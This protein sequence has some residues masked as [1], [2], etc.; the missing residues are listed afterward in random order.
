MGYGDAKPSSGDS[1][2]RPRKRQDR[3]G[4]VYVVRNK[5]GEPP[6]K[7]S[8]RERYWQRERRGVVCRPLSAA[9]RGVREPVDNAAGVPHVA[10]TRK[11]PVTPLFRAG[12]RC[13]HKEPKRQKGCPH[14][15]KSQ[16][17]DRQALFILRN[18]KPKEERKAAYTRRE[19]GSPTRATNR[20]LSLKDAP[21]QQIKSSSEIQPP[22][23]T[24]K[25]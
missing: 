21:L 10:D 6:T 7:F 9:A 17:H 23:A 19:S 5:K 25:S 3:G 16:I 14:P 4:F 13:I 22:E 15:S 1:V 11:M 8:D 24:L 12:K 18:L 2:L 20:G